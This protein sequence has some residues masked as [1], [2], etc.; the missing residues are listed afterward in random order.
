MSSKVLLYYKFT[1][2]SDPETVRLWQRLLCEKLGLT[3]RIIISEHGINGTLG[4][5]IEDVKAYVR[6]M[7]LHS[8]FKDINYKWSEGTGN[9]FPRLSVKVRDELVTLAPDEKF[10]VFDAGIGLRP[11]RWHKLLSENPD[12]PLL[13]ARNEYESDIGTFKGA[14]TPKINTFKEIK[15]T[16][17]DLD[18]DEP[19][20][21]FCTG[22]VRCE[23]LSAYMK[24]LGFKEVYH[25]DGGIVKYGQRYGDRGLWD[26]KCYVFDGRMNIGFGE[27]GAESTDVASCV[28]CGESSSRQVNCLT[29]KCQSQLVVC[30]NC[31]DKERPT[32][33]RCEQVEHIV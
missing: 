29:L 7:N 22:D 30:E 6:A 3:G 19:V 24:H 17:K 13:D 11:A 4:G 8:L 16:L 10:D 23:Y 27:D 33:W 15:E 9:D 25:L 1:P 14:I 31:A 12:M 21:T 5:D 26:G 32:C 28:Y 2:V 18:R 20:A